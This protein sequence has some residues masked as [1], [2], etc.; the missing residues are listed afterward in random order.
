MQIRKP[1]LLAAL[2]ATLVGEQPKQQPKGPEIEV[3]KGIDA[4]NGVA[5]PKQGQSKSTNRRAPRK[6]AAAKKAAAAKQI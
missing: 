3:Q 4:T 6:K 5:G 2:A 1:L